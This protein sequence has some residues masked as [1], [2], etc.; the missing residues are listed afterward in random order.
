VSFYDGATLLST[1]AVNAS[2]HATYSTAH[3]SAGTHI[4]KATYSG[5]ANYASGST[6]VTIV[7]RAGS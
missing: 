2:G 1:V 3:L 7:L 4:I 5:S 6:S